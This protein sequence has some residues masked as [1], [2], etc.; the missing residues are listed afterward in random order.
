MRLSAFPGSLA[1][2]LAGAAIASANP[3]PT[4]PVN[5]AQGDPLQNVCY[6]A[7]LQQGQLAVR[8]SPGGEA[9]AGLDNIDVVE[10]YRQQGDWACVRVLQGPNPQLTG[11]EGWVNRNYLE[12]GSELNCYRAC[13]SLIEL[14]NQVNARTRP[15][16]CSR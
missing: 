10:V 6:V 8:N 13:G 14:R 11:I 9:R 16:M 4:D 3:P 5:L 15:G 12:C 7:N 1:L 2:A